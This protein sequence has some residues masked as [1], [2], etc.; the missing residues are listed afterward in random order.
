MKLRFQ[1]RGFDSRNE[2]FIQETKL[3]FWKRI[4]YLNKKRMTLMRFRIFGNN[5]H[6]LFHIFC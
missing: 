5:T 1:E 4:I 6:V 2:A 3:Q